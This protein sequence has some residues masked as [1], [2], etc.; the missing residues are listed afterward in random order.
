MKKL[1]VVIL[2]SWLVAVV[3]AARPLLLTIEHYPTP[4]VISNL[5]CDAPSST[6]IHCTVDTNKPTTVNIQ[7]QIAP[8]GWLTSSAA[9]TADG[10]AHEITIGSLAGGLNFYVRTKATDAEGTQSFSDYIN[11]VTP[12]AASIPVLS[13]FAASAVGT[14]S[15]TFTWT[16]DLSADSQ[17]ECGT[18]TGV[19]TLTSTLDASTVT[20]HSNQIT[21]LSQSTTYYCRGISDAGS[22]AGNSGEVVVMTATAGTLSPPLLGDLDIR[23][24]DANRVC[25]DSDADGVCDDYRYKLKLPEDTSGWAGPTDLGTN[26]TAASVANTINSGSGC[27]IFEADGEI[28]LSGGTHIEFTRNCFLLRGKNSTLLKITVQSGASHGN[29]CT[30]TGGDIAGFVNACGSRG[31]TQAWTSGY[32]KDDNV[33]GVADVSAFAVYQESAP[34]TNN[35]FVQVSSDATGATCPEHLPRPASTNRAVHD[36][37]HRVVAIVDSDGAGAGTAGTLTIDPPLLIDYDDELP[38]CGNFDVRPATLPV[39]GF[40]YID[41]STVDGDEG[42]T[43]PAID[44]IAGCTFARDPLL[45]YRYAQGWVTN[46][47]FHNHITDFFTARFGADILLMGNDFYNPS[48]GYT[49]VQFQATFIRFGEGTT[50]SGVVNSHIHDIEQAIQLR[51]GGRGNVVADNFMENIRRSGIHLH[52]L[53]SGPNLVERNEIRGYVSDRTWGLQGPENITYR[54][55]VRADGQSPSNALGRYHDGPSPTLGPPPASPTTSLGT[56]YRY[57]HIGD[58]VDKAAGWLQTPYAFIDDHNTPDAHV[59]FMWTAAWGN[60]GTLGSCSSC[61]SSNNVLSASQPAAHAAA[62]VPLSFFRFRGREDEWPPYWC[63]EG[64]DFTDPHSSIGAF[65]ATQGDLPAKRRANA[66]SCTLCDSVGGSGC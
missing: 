7:Y 52:G 53:Y 42:C 23:N 35:T 61:T 57:V 4:A 24:I 33:I 12:S 9:T 37:L 51:E 5:A 56:G 29:D 66:Q 17:V 65:S 45:H 47:R 15:A 40:D 36:A 26:P 32:D 6:E 55:Y 11:V 21:G 25:I 3:A 62:S 46:S 8:I 41:F 34:Y 58:R 19:Y 30:G 16:T 18:S 63:Q 54:N 27:E 22:G 50:S 43:F 49:Q 20:S 38:N 44:S 64:A 1:A 28:T 13:G 14:T 2:G 48:S 31:S 59:E 39:A 10:R 60:A